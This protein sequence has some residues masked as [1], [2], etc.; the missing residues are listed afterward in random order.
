MTESPVKLSSY[1]L[2]LFADL[3]RKFEII[4]EEEF[5][6]VVQ[7]LN[8]S[9]LVKWA[10]LSVPVISLPAIR[11]LAHHPAKEAETTLIEILKSKE[12]FDHLE[13]SVSQKV[14]VAIEALA[15]RRNPTVDSIL[16][17]ILDSGP[18]MDVTITIAQA[19]KGHPL[20]REKIQENSMSQLKDI[21]DEESGLAKLLIQVFLGEAD[22]EEVKE[23]LGLED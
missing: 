12:E 14:F 4:T 19:L 6:Y 5:A 2:L 16:F 11:A 13:V 3:V 15:K 23:L 22:R 17:E 8:L 1:S 9:E 20:L 18:D 21:S 7:Q 10:K